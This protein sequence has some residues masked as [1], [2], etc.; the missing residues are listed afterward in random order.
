M[1]KDNILIKTDISNNCHSMAAAQAMSIVVV[2]VK[3]EHL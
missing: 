2:A 3:N 1:M